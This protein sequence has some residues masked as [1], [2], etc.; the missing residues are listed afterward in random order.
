MHNLHDGITRRYGREAIE[1]GEI[2]S[3][4]SW[5]I[6]S[7][8]A[9]QALRD[10]KSAWQFDEYRAALASVERACKHATTED[11]CHLFPV[12]EWMRRVVSSLECAA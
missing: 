10:A 7:L 12:E 9:K 5:H 3:F 2:F 8:K 11:L 1:T 4:V 6:E